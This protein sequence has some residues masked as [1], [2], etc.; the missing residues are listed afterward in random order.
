MAMVPPARGEKQASNRGH[1]VANRDW[2]RDAGAT[3]WCHQCKA[4]LRHEAFLRSEAVN[5]T[6]RGMRW[7]PIKVASSS[8]I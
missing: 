7:A 6:K 4:R 8:S 3:T 5:W 1:L 2:W